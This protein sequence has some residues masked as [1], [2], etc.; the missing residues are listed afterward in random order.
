MWYVLACF[1]LCLP[2]PLS[3]LPLHPSASFRGSF[4]DPSDKSH[5]Y[6]VEPLNNLDASVRRQCYP[7]MAIIMSCCCI[8]SSMFHTNSHITPGQVSQHQGCTLTFRTDRTVCSMGYHLEH[9]KF[10]KF[11]NC[12]YKTTTSPAV[13]IAAIL[14]HVDPID[15]FHCTTHIQL[16][17]GN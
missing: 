15:R 5:H 11:D 3:L 14:P 2:P 1:D 17:S 16:V 6:H 10:L 7:T 9:G 4:G 12:T 8:G 13:V